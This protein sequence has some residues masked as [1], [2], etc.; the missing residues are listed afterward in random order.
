MKNPITAVTGRPEPLINRA[1]IVALVAALLTLLEAFGVPVTA[2]QQDAINQVL[3]ILA[4]LIVAFL[5]RRVSIPV[6]K[7]GRE[8]GE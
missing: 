4:P 3:V 7:P 2:D 1:F 6:E 5:G 8:G